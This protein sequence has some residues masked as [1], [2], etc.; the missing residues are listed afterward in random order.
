MANPVAED[1]AAPVV[2][3]VWPSAPT[4]V[5]RTLGKPVIPAPVRL[6]TTWAQVTF[7]V[8]K[9]GQGHMPRGPSGVSATHSALVSVHGWSGQAWLVVNELAGV[10]RSVT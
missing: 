6:D 9:E 1:V 5:I 8:P 4:R 3:S 10:V 2:A 7:P